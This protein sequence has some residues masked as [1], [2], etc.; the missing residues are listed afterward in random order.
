M[1]VW[2]RCAPRWQPLLLLWR[3][4]RRAERPVLVEQ[5]RTVWWLRLVCAER[6]TAV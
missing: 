1:L 5:A 4:A 2:V 6:L 3:Y